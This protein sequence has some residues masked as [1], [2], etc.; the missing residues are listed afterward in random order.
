[1][2]VLRVVCPF[3]YAPDSC[4]FNGNQQQ[5]FMNPYPFTLVVTVFLMLLWAYAFLSKLF[6]FYK[7]KRAMLTQVFPRW[8]GRIMTYMVPVIELLIII[9]LWS[10]KTRLVGMYASLALMGLFTIYAGGA[11]FRVYERHPCPCGGL[12]GRLGWYKHF[13]VNIMLTFISL[14]GVLLVQL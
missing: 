14:I 2:T 9:L 6:F 13:K 5:L 12:F 11:V 1:M 8:A 10:A 4:N 3:F 7:F